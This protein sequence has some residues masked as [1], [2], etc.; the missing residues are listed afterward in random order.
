[1]NRVKIKYILLLL[2]CLLLSSCAL[3]ATHQLHDKTKIVKIYDSFEPVEQC[4][5][6][7]ELV[8]SEGTWYNYLFI[9]NKELTIASVNDLKNQASEI[10]ANAV[11][12]QYNL[13]F[14]T[15]VTFFAQAYKCEE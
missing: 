1:M 3:L 7:N 10:G 9:S 14:N 12:I 8:S 5:F 13:N 2:S 6:I 15:S 11:H 4:K